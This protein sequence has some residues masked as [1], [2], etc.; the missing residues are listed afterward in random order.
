V[1]LEEA[2][3]ADI[4]EHPDDDAP[5]LIYADWLEEHGQSERAEFIRVQLELARLSEDAPHWP[6]LKSREAALREEY[7]AA[8]TE[9]LSDLIPTSDT[10][11]SPRYEFRRGFIEFL[12][13]EGDAF[14]RRGADYFARTPLREIWLP[15]QEEY[16]ALASCPHLA[17]LSTLNLTCARLS[18][19]FSPD[20][21]IS[22]PYLC[23][24]TDFYLRN[25]PDM[26]CLDRS[27]L[28]VLATTP[29]LNRLRTLD[30]SSNWI[31]DEGVE[32]V[33]RAHC[34]SGLEHLHLGQSDIGDAGV[35][36]LAA[37]PALSNLR[38]LDLEG[39]PIGEAGLRAL[40]KSRYLKRLTTLY[41]RGLIEEEDVTPVYGA[42]RRALR[43]RFGKG[44]R[45]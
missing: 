12:Q 16:D 10:P 35:R 43:Q 23:G 8:W 33:A 19:E 45:F 17:R 37:T 22:S 14:V 11:F 2:F 44:V 34:L 3:L 38:S 30:L 6:R 7:E 5:R 25:D 32:I 4:C 28:V 18:A 15:E 40:L 26:G 24:L 29:H 21:L 39:N 20:V 27:G 13:L 41:V 42:T 9:P 31:G 36:M 1:S